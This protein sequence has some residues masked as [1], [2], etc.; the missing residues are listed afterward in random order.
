MKT[1]AD[2]SDTGGFQIRIRMS[3]FGAGE[4]RRVEVNGRHFRADRTTG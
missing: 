2:A 4:L 3:A 1:A